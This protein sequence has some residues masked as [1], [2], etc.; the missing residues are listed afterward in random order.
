MP[1]PLA[2][3][4]VARDLLTRGFST[5]VRLLVGDDVAGFGADDL[6]LKVLRDVLVADLA[7]VIDDSDINIRVAA[8]YLFDVNNIGA[9]HHHR[10]TNVGLELVKERFI[11]HHGSH[12][13]TR[14]MQ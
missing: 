11:Q 2:L 7:Q 1:D 4:D 14:A 6:N 10:K 5:A 12:G 3:A 13:Q 8:P 9:T